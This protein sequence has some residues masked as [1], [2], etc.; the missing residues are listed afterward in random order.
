MKEFILAIIDMYVG[1]LITFVLALAALLAFLAILVLPGVG[2]YLLLGKIPEHRRNLASYGAMAVF[3]GLG[4]GYYVQ[5][6]LEQI[7][8]AGWRDRTCWGSDDDPRGLNKMVPLLADAKKASTPELAKEAISPALLVHWR[9]FAWVDDYLSRRLLCPPDTSDSFGFLFA[10][11][12]WIFTF[13]VM[14]VELITRYLIWSFMWEGVL[15]F[16]VPY[17]APAVIIG[18]FVGLRIYH[19]RSEKV[20]LESDAP[21]AGPSWRPSGGAERVAHGLDGR[22]SF[23]AAQA[24]VLLAVTSSRSNHSSMRRPQPYR[25]ALR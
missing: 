24:F 22:M 21:R 2:V 1:D 20:P 3:V 11:L 7:K 16:M 14:L 8:T 12:K 13:P 5:L 15:L 18:A 10:I 17:V 23:R 6:P 9:L 4:V 19:D 25:R